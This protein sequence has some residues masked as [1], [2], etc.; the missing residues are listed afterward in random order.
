MIHLEFCLRNNDFGKFIF[1]EIGDDLKQKDIC[2]LRRFKDGTIRESVT[3]PVSSWGGQAND[4]VLDK[5]VHLISV[6]H[7]SVE[8]QVHRGKHW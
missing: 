4:F 5:I 7:P 8:V 6:H 1:F 2:Q 3:I